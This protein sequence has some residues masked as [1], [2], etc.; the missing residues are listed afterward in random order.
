MKMMHRGEKGFTL[1]EL[2][3]V[4]AILGVIAAVVA[5]NV[6]GFFGRGTVQAANTELH[7]V[8][9]SIISAMADAESGTLTEPALGDVNYWA[10]GNGTIYVE[11]DI[12]GNITTYD[13]ADYVYGPL[14]AAYE[15]DHE[16]SI[17]KG[18][19]GETGDPAE[20]ITAL[21][22]RSPWANIHWDDTNKNW[23]ADE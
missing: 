6:S 1:I 4:I 18:W 14:R 2:L 5:L 13:A 9:T 3:V 17:V 23:A 20:A 8:Q 15:I 10:G 22:D 16:G 7:Q 21:S 11:V 19:L 12:G